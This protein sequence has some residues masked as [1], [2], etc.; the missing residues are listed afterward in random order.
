MER[1]VGGD[2]GPLE[3][4]LSRR[5]LRLRRR[6]S[7]PNLPVRFEVFFPGEQ[8]AGSPL[9]LTCNGRILRIENYGRRFAV[10]ALIENRQVV[11]PEESGMEQNRRSWK[12]VSPFPTVVAG[13]PGFRSVVRDLSRS[14]AFIEDD[15][16]FPVGKRFQLRLRSEDTAEEI[17]VT[18]I[19]RRVE[20]QVGMAVEFVALS[21]S[22][23]SRLREFLNNGWGGQTSHARSSSDSPSSRDAASG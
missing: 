23:S 7:P 9:K 8:T 17:E 3:G 18:A 19:V 16:P 15:R 14:G 21:G 6:S 22:A 13:Y 5:H 1:A 12:R 20:P 4:H 2:R 10:A 11:E